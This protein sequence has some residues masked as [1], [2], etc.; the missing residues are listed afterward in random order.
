MA[1][2]LSPD[3]LSTGID[4]LYVRQLRDNFFLG[5][6]LWN[7]LADNTDEVPGGRQIVD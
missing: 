6:P 7:K 3:T 2:P 1:T 5:T 4:R